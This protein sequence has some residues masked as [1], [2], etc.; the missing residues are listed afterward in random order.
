M[1]QPPH[2]R[3]RS[4]DNEQERHLC[5][6]D[7]AEFDLA[8]GYRLLANMRDTHAAMYVHRRLML[9]ELDRK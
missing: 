5:K 3:G 6:M 2:R 7:A 4:A 1:A 8:G 9:D